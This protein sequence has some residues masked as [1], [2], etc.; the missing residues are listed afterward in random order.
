M[1]KESEIVAQK[2]KAGVY[3]KDAV[4]WFNFIYT[5]PRTEF[6][7]LIIACSL[8]LTGFAIG[9]GAFIKFFPLEPEVPIV[10]YRPFT[11]YDYLT[12]EEMSTSERQPTDQAVASY[13]IREYVRSREQYID[14]RLPRDMTY[15]ATMSNDDVADEY[16]NEVSL[17]NPN[18][19][20]LIY[21]NK[22]QVYA[23]VYRTML[24][25]AAGNQLNKE[26][27]GL[28]ASARVLYS[29]YVIFDDGTQQKTDHSADISFQY[30]QIIVDQKTNEVTQNPKLVVTSYKTKSM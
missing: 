2:M 23:D 28:P 4:E 5:R 21:G 19:P 14:A 3:Y 26:S 13:F 20:K 16:F 1:E 24:F 10:V 25:D 9:L 15:V 29:T 17:S 27:K 6:S 18:N 12:L 8:A 11:P 30:T 22:A 7:L